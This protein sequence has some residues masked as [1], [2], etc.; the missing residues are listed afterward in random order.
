[1]EQLGNRY[2]FSFFLTSSYD[3]IS[4]RIRNCLEP[5]LGRTVSLKHNSKVNN[6]K[7]QQ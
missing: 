3:I 4:Q 6:T 1:M 7:A 5:L 2:A